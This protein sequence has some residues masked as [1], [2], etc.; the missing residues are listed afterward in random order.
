MAHE[1]MARGSSSQATTNGSVTVALG[2]LFQL[3]EARRVDE[4]RARRE[5]EERERARIA[6][7]A[8]VREREARELE[9]RVEAEA[10][11]RV[12][13]ETRARREE[14]DAEG[15]I[16]ALREELTRTVAAREEALA[17]ARDAAST[18]DES[19]RASGWGVG[20]IGAVVG[21]VGALAVVL[22]MGRASTPPAVSAPPARA[23]IVSPRVAA[24][25]EVTADVSV[26]GEPEPAVEDTAPAAP[27]DAR[28]TRHH[29]RPPARTT[30][31]EGTP[32]TTPRQGVS[33]LA[34]DESNDVL[35]GIEHDD[36]LEGG[37]RRGSR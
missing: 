36:A 15:R 13:A 3:E 16:R 9:L 32:A 12:E 37:R 18:V 11:A 27:T 17:R 30:T 1:A 5:R 34:W 21:A 31:R 2:E 10:R 33:G 35:G 14:S 23:V 8:A 20:A 24:P 26:A 22:G 19:R 7:V 6:E 28:S 25:P 29:A 4:E